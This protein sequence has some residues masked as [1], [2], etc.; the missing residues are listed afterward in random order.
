MNIQKMWKILSELD[1]LYAHLM[2][3][4]M[5]NFSHEIIDRDDF[6]NTS[7][8]NILPEQIIETIQDQLTDKKYTEYERC[9]VEFCIT[10]EYVVAGEN[11]NCIKHWL[12][13]HKK[14]LN[15]SDLKY[16]KALNNS[17]VS[18]YQI[19]SVSP[20]ESIELQDMIEVDQPSVIIA[21]K[22]LSK[23]AKESGFIATRLLKTRSKADSA[24]YQISNTLLY[25]PDEVAQSSINVIKMMTQ[26]MNSHLIRATDLNTPDNQLLQKKLWIKEI[27]EHWYIHNCDHRSETS[28]PVFH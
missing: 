11:W 9:V 14:Q 25:L 6:Y 4:V 19:V 13:H 18:V 1:L 21:N 17:Y 23:T 7:P 26:A 28:E 16:L 22:A 10:N 3:E 20:N 8:G 24:N 27:L 15:K 2:N 5:A 12:D